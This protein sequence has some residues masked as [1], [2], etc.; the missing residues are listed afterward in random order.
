MSPEKVLELL[1]RVRDGQLDPVQAAA[2]LAQLPFA[3]TSAIASQWSARRVMR[4]G[5]WL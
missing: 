3:L 4:L 1:S 5:L 2:R